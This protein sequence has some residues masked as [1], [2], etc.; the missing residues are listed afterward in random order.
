VGVEPES[1]DPGAWGL[2]KGVVKVP[3]RAV[4]KTSDRT[5]SRKVDFASGDPW[6]AATTLDDKQLEEKFSRLTT[7]LASGDNRERIHDLVEIIFQLEKISNLEEL[8]I[9]FMV[10]EKASSAEIES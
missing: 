6:D 4:V 8:Q 9:P 5:F 7:S 10:P 3:S 1:Q 2:E